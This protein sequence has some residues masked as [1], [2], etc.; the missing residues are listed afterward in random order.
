M[1]LDKFSQ[2]IITTSDKININVLT[3]GQGYPIL[4][5]HGYPQ[6]HLIWRGIA[7]YLS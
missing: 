6:T 4:F 7:P 3:S 5:L 1:M 2:Q